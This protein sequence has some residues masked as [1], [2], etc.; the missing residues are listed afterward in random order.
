MF[1]QYE[2]QKL[3][4]YP[5]NLSQFVEKKPECR[6]Y[7]ELASTGGLVFK[8]PNPGRLEGINSTTRK[9]CFLEN[10]DFCYP[11]AKENQL[12]GCT[13]QLALGSRVVRFRS[14]SV[15]SSHGSSAQSIFVFVVCC[16]AVLF[17]SVSMTL[18][19]ECTFAY[20]FD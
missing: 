11:G 10:V 19:N 15:P 9:I 13:C 1:P 18:A 12:T 5:G 3:V 14:F 2:N 6:S 16:V 4:R 7:Y 17:F 20:L 8:F